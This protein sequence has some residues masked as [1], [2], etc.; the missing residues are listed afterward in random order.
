MVVR[1]T[2]ATFTVSPSTTGR[3]A[4]PFARRRDGARRVVG[5]VSCLGALVTGG[6][7]WG[8]DDIVV[9]DVEKDP[10][11]RFQVIALDQ[12]IR[13]MLGNG[14]DDVE[15]LVERRTIGQLELEIARIDETCGLTDA[16][17]SKLA[18]AARLESAEAAERLARLTRRFAGRT[19][20]LQTREGQQEWQRF[21]Q[22]MHAIQRV[23]PRP[24][25]LRHFLGRT[26][27][28]LLDER[29]RAAWSEE[30][31]LRQ[32]FQWRRMVDVGMTQTESIAGLTTSQHEAL[33]AV[34]VEH[35]LR[36]DLAKAREMFG[37][38][39]PTVCW[40]ALSRVDAERLQ[41]IVDTRQWEKLRGLIRQ[42]EAWRP[43]FESMTLPG[44]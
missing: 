43:T 3:R 29:Q 12:Q 27:W 24:G 26:V 33:V 44:E 35:P 32:A 10:Q 42:G 15:G 7:L 2:S 6:L 30:S 41:A 5:I 1:M 4:R 11:Q 21:H 9:E 38:Q 34:L 18:V 19:V 40:Y 16:Q 39:N 28:G 25:N 13:G 17:R 14:R 20:D 22:E 23:A 31:A 36:I 8:G 37:D